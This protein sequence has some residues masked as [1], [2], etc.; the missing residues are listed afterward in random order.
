MLAMNFF[1]NKPSSK[2][3]IL[4]IVLFSNGTSTNIF[5]KIIWIKYPGE[6]EPLLLFELIIF[7]GFFYPDSPSIISFSFTA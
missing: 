5:Y 1:Y 2:A 6:V 4:H 3:K 7:H